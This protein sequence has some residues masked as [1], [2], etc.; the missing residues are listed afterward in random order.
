MRHK[1]TQTRHEVYS[2]TRGIY[3][4]RNKRGK[5][6]SGINLRRKQVAQKKTPIW[7]NGGVIRPNEHSFE[8]MGLHSPFPACFST[9][10]WSSKP[11]HP[12]CFLVRAN[13]ALFD[14]WIRSNPC[15]PWPNRIFEALDGFRTLRGPWVGLG[16]HV[17][18]PIR[19]SNLRSKCLSLVRNVKYLEIS[20][21]T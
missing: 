10:P 15:S 12:N 18:A 4:L 13:L 8:R 7:S 6:P 20:E 21:N 11:I 1:G 17:M 19:A 5:K 16:K 9:F 14:W 2:D 3:K